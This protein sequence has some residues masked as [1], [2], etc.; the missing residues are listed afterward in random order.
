MGRNPRANAGMNG[1]SPEIPFT[2]DADPDTTPGKAG[3]A[4]R[5]GESGPASTGA[6]AVGMQ[7]REARGTRE[8]LPSPRP[9]AV[10]ADPKGNEPCLLHDF[11]QDQL[12]CWARQEGNQRGIVQGHAAGGFEKNTPP[13]YTGFGLA[14]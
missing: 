1:T 14:G 3:A 4:A 8:I 11:P 12:L 13:W 6:L 7:G 10:G 9:P 2:V 5:Q